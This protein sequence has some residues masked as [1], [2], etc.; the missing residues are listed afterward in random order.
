L[1]KDRYL[2]SNKVLFCCNIGL[3]F[4]LVFTCISM[5]KNWTEWQKRQNQCSENVSSVNLS[6]QNIPLIICPK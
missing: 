6:D 2:F 5:I 3:S 1:K 4:F